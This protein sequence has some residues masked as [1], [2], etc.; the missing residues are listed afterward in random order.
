V[1]WNAPCG[2]LVAA[3]Q[4]DCESALPKLA[5][6]QLKMV[7]NA[8]LQAVSARVVEE[9]VERVDVA[10]VEVEGEARPP[11]SARRARPIAGPAELSS[12]AVRL[13]IASVAV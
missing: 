1:R 5:P 4:R 10:M 11:E 2:R 9:G 6:V 13:R 12:G 8:N 7:K 3:R